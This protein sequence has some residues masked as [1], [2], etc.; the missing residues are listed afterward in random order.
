MEWWCV[1]GVLTGEEGRSCTQL[2]KFP[3]WK[4]GS[5]LSATSIQWK[6]LPPLKTMVERQSW[7]LK[8]LAW[9]KRTHRYL[10]DHKKF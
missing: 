9:D 4:N 10:R 6:S 1:L 5:G 8:A 7:G 3:S 2:T